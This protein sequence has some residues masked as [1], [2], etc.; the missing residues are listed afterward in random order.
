MWSWM[1]GDS[2]QLQDAGK[3]A[4]PKVLAVSQ[5]QGSPGS[6]SGLWGSAPGT[7]WPSV[8]AV[9]RLQSFVGNGS[10]TWRLQS[11]SFPRTRI[12]PWILIKTIRKYTIP[13]LH[14]RGGWN[15]KGRRKKAILQEW[16]CT[17]VTLI[18]CFF[19]FLL[20]SWPFSHSITLLELLKWFH[21]SWFSLIS[22]M[23]RVR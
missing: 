13:F 6:R 8:I 22:Q 21:A 23:S 18:L 7:H 14:P 20:W 3:L 4:W 5:E 12:T 11:A 10:L 16:D 17:T 15:K 9:L 19:F 1:A 2:V